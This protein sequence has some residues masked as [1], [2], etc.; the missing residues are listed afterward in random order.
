MSITILI[1]AWTVLPDYASVNLSE[2]GIERI[3]EIL[4]Y[5]NVDL[6]AGIWTADDARHLMTLMDFPWLRLLLEPWD[7]NPEQANNMVDGIEDVLGDALPHVPRLI[8]SKIPS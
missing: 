4:V 2:P 5:R 6:E 7:S 3:L 1:D 8:H